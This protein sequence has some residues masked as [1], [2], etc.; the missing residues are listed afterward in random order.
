MFPVNNDEE[1]T[2]I[3]G[4]CGFV[5][6]I[7]NAIKIAYDQDTLYMF[8]R[9]SFPDMRTLLNSIQSMYTQ[10]VTELD[11]NALIKSFDCSELLNIIINGNDPVENYKFIAANYAS[12]PDDAMMSISK[13]VVD[14]IRMNYP[15]FAPKIPYIITTVAEYMAQITTAPDR[16]L[17]LLA[18]VFKLQMI[19]KS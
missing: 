8:V 12:N 17:V 19:I 18:C 13:S 15:Q 3:T 4:Y 11:K 2:M 10:G 1:N 6:N 5:A 16:L 7:L 14:F 9:N